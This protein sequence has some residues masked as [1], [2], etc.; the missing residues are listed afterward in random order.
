M[1]KSESHERAKL[2]AFGQGRP[3][4]PTEEPTAMAAETTEPR[5][6]VAVRDGLDVWRQLAPG[7]VEGGENHAIYS[8]KMKQLIEAGIVRHDPAT[9]F[10][11][12]PE[13][14]QP[15]ITQPADVVDVHV[16]AKPAKKPAAKGKKPAAAKK[17]AAKAKKPAAAK[18]AKAAK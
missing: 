1:S 17:P 2:L 8:N 18:K 11:D 4:T 10:A 3:E 6:L 13:G 12:W 14:V 5:V 15:L 16:D 7:E 9:M